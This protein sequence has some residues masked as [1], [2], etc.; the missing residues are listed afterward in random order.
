MQLL[1]FSFAFGAFV[2]PLIARQF[3]SEM[4]EKD[5]NSTSQSSGWDHINDSMEW[6]H[7]NTVQEH[8]GGE[9]LFRVAYWI[10]SVAFVPT[11]LANG[12]FVIKYDLLGFLR[13]KRQ[14]SQENEP[15]NEKEEER[16]EQKE[17][18]EEIGMNGNKELHLS[19]TE[20]SENERCVS[21]DGTH[22]PRNVLQD[23]VPDQS[24]AATMTKKKSTAFKIGIVVILAL[25][26]LVYVGMEVAY[27]S[28]IFTVVVTGPLDFSKSQGAVIQSLFWGTFSFIRL[29][30]IVLALL[31]IKAS[32][33]ITGN[34][35]GSLVASVIM[36][37]SPHNATAIWLASAVLGMSYAS[38]YPT[39]IT[40]MSETVEATGATASILVTGGII[41]DVS[42][43]AI[44]GA[45]V[46]KVSPDS[47]FYLTFAGTLIS[48]ILMLLLFI[49]AHI[50]KK[51]NA[52]HLKTG[53]THEGSQGSGEHE[54]QV[55][56]IDSEEGSE[57]EMT[58]M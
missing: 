36:V 7:N 26:M 53:G 11:L 30:S 55:K 38:I 9:S 21:S 22:D 56:L 50:Y 24:T 23:T 54:E 19:P 48:T 43:P 1:H 27:G 35:S 34:L 37:S 40:W 44:A 5:S 20:S 18:Q 47:L 3:I 41:G 58:D 10:L 39:A 57:E 52:G 15:V 14:A 51:W 49:L 25:F 45:L 46:Y 33:M 4:K 2:A 16:D 13:R 8:S 12:F 42:I 32:V 17:G 29:F 28:W 31:N 6:G